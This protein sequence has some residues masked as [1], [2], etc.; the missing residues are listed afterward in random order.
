MARCGVREHSNLFEMRE[1]QGATTKK[2][3]KRSN[4]L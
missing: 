4:E 3:T 1:V 2:R